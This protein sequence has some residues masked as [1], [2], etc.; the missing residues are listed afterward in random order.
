M[1][2]I[3]VRSAGPGA[4]EPAPTSRLRWRAPQT[5]R[6]P[7]RPRRR[8]RSSES[9]W[10][11]AHTRKSHRGD[12][13]AW[14]TGLR[15]HF[16]RF[17]TRH[18]SQVQ[19][20]RAGDPSREQCQRISGPTGTCDRDVL[21]AWLGD[22]RVALDSLLEN[23]VKWRS[24]QNAQRRLAHRRPCQRRLAR[25]AAWLCGRV[26]RDHGTSHEA[27]SS[28]D[29][30]SY[31]QIRCVRSVSYLRHASG[32]LGLRHLGEPVSQPVQVPLPGEIRCLRPGWLLIRDAGQRRGGIHRGDR[33]IEP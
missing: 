8:G 15:K 6:G 14:R 13:T 31:N 7:R 19:P 21:S 26:D 17:R 23:S 33:A 20:T 2:R 4:R 29:C 28:P 27:A 30:P 18:L 10:R 25:C 5:R 1:M 22:D 12:R 16:R 32:R 11:F 3:D 9:S 24:R